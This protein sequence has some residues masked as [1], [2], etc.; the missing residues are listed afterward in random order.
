[1]KTRTAVTVILALC[2]VIGIFVVGMWFG[3]EIVSLGN[4]SRICISTPD[5]GEGIVEIRVLLEDGAPAYFVR[6]LT[7]PPFLADF[8]VV[9]DPYLTRSFDELKPSVVYSNLDTLS[10]RTGYLLLSVL[11]QGNLYWVKNLSFFIQSEGG[12]WFVATLPNYC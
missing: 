6:K 9:N 5:R 7:W 12:E 8:R 3:R 10:S 2:S 11:G 4:T 1:M